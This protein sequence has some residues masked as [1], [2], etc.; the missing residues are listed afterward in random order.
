MA[1][2]QDRNDAD[3]NRRSTSTL[4]PLLKSDNDVHNPKSFGIMK[5]A[6]EESTIKQFRSS[7]KDY[8]LT[9]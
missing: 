8:K 7:F 1:V 2:R 5:F 3:G 6:D 9:Y 4:F